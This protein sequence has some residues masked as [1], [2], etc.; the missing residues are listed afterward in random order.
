MEC[1]YIWRCANNGTFKYTYSLMH[2]GRTFC[3][4]LWFKC[5]RLY[6]FYILY[7][8]KA[9][10][11]GAETTR[12]HMTSDANSSVYVNDLREFLT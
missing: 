3:R 2:A 12:T 1:K 8:I 10:F 9:K 4:L 7:N 5:G 6:Q 11:I